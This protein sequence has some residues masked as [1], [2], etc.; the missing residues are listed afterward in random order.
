MIR[1][2]PP[3]VKLTYVT[4]ACTSVMPVP[5]LPLE[6]EREI[7]SLA[8][9]CMQQAYSLLFVSRR[10]CDFARGAV[11]SLCIEGDILPSTAAEILSL[12]S[13]ITNL[14]LWIAPSDFKNGTTNPLL[15]PLN[16]LPLMSLS[17]SISL[18]FRDTH[19]VSLSAFKAFGTLT[20]LE[21]LNGWVLWNS[22]RTKP[23][24]VAFLL[25]LS[26]L[27]VIVFHISEDID[28][29]QTFLESNFLNDS[30][31]VL[32][33]QKPTAWDEFGGGDMFLWKAADQVVDRRYTSTQG[34]YFYPESIL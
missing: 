21:I 4:E 12:C 32:V 9:D 6:L 34:M 25:T 26:H 14:A 29:V 5:A 2:V 10:H 16:D 11:Q 13:G 30:R 8:I 23:K 7:T 18:I 17:L 3:N 19:L 20:H 24:L 22:T 15:Q 27:R 1:P 33:S 31:I 28:A